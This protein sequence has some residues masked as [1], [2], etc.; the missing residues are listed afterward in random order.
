[1]KRFKGNQGNW[2]IGKNGSE[3]ISDQRTNRKGYSEKD[4]E[5]EKEYYGGYII[6]ES[7][8]T[9]ANVQLLVTSKDLLDASIQALKYLQRTGITYDNAELYNTLDKAINKALRQ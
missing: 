1:M 6:C 3:V 4:W 9:I 2:S 5:S 7:I 8:E